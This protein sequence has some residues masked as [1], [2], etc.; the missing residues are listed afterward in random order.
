MIRLLALSLSLLAAAPLFAQDKAAP[1]GP[2]DWKVEVV[3]EQ[4]KVNYCSVVACAPDGRVFL[5]EDPM[6]MVGPPN[7]PIDRVLCIHPDGK[8]TVFAEKLYAVFGLVYM[9][10][11]LYVHHSPKFSVFDDDGAV[12]KNRVDLIDCT[13]P[14]PWGGMND[15]IPANFR[16]G[17]DG[18]FYMSAGDKGIYGAVGKDGSKAEIWGGG[19]LRFRPDGTKLEVFSSG[20][21]NHLD[22]AINAEDEMFT[23]DN[24]DDGNGW[25]TKVTHM[26]DGGF[27]GYPWDYKPRRPYTLW[28]MADYGGG[29]PTGGLAYNEDALPEEYHGNL[30]MCEWGKGQIARFIVERE[31]ASYKIV[32]RD[33]FLTKGDKEFRPVGIAV[34]AD[35]MSI[36][37]AD[38]NFGGWSNRSAKAG[39]LIK[40][41]YA[42]KSQAKPKPEW[43]V[44]A[45]QGQAFKATIEELLQGVRHPAQSVR[46]VA[47]RRLAE[48]GKEAI[49]PLEALLKDAKAPAFARWSALWTLDR[50]DGGAASRATIAGLLNDS[51]ASVRRQAARQIGTRQVVSAAPELIKSLDDKDLS[52]RFQAATALGRLGSLDA[53][54]PLVA[55]LD[56]SDL[57]ARYATFLA[58]HRIGMAEPKAWPEIARGFRSDRTPIREGTLFAFRETY[59]PTAIDALAQTAVDRTVP[60]ETREAVLALLGEL[61][62]KRPAWKGQWWGTQPV[63]SLPPARTETWDGS[64]SAFAALTKGLNDEDPIVRVGAAK[65]M[66]Q[67]NHPQAAM[68]LLA[69][70]NVEKDA[71]ARKAMVQSLGE[72]R[73]INDA[74]AKAADPAAI[75]LLKNDAVLP[76]TL[77]FISRLPSVSPA[78]TEAMLQLSK[79][80]WPAREQLALVEALGLSK[81]PK[82]LSA[83]VFMSKGDN[84]PVRVKAIQLLANR[85]GEEA[86]GALTASLTDKKAL[87]RKEAAI[88]L[89]KRKDKAA[90]PALLMALRDK[91]TRFDVANALAQTPDVRA[92][93][94]YLEGMESKN[95]KLREDATRAL[96]VIKM[97]AM[98]AV[99]DRVTR[100]P[101]LVAAAVLQL[102]KIYKNVP[103]AS[104][105]ALFTIAAKEV[106]V[107]D[108]MAASLNEKGDGNRGKKIFADVKGVACIKCHRAGKEGGEV[109]PDLSGIGVKYNRNQLTEHVLYPSK[110]ILDG[111]DMMIAE[112]KSGQIIQGIQRGEAGG[113]VT[114]VDAEG[115]K[116][117]LKKD[118]LESLTKS[119]KSIMPEG[120][121][122]VLTIGEF[123]DLVSYLETLQEKKADEKK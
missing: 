32:R 123:A 74:F 45:A 104:K 35:G 47:M 79:R 66:V 82:V 96:S 105:S 72:V 80:E 25:W 34:S 50:I 58:L 44:P 60:S 39:R 73:N 11:K 23:Y 108:F 118:E 113:E 97:E 119:T 115:K 12:G 102:Q 121:H 114:L 111:Y 24:T 48:R 16:L 92:V 86:T 27:Y 56:E 61:A 107:D 117:V 30:F 28:M 94:V 49:V 22:M 88:A 37:I 65:G 85:P 43:Y 110:Q 93:D 55:K 120:L 116:H 63:R 42:G 9:D 29:S 51:D 31:G 100:T 71:S 112:T 103:E 57:F 77:A 33:A 1:K 5:A 52:V 68:D 70:L 6:D 8:I 7:Q 40:A 69:H 3:A 89:G 84:E 46:L 95:N 98:Q 10:G 64:K 83:L 17:M 21:R 78:L 62:Q 2:A 15:H 19:I 81:E 13:H 122:A 41:T 38:W 76:E 59:E 106:K 91:E 87:I 101:P 20:T 14:Q 18:Y 90:I 75:D 67:S 54:K 36:Y 53:V 26:V 4:P 99:E 109:G